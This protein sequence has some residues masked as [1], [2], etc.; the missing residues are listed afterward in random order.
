MP[1][2]KDHLNKKQILE[3]IKLRRSG[4]TIPMIASMYDRHHTTI[5]YWL[6]KVAP[7]LMP[8]KLKLKENVGRNQREG[9]AR[10]LGFKVLKSDNPDKYT[11]KVIVAKQ[12][13]NCS[14]SIGAKRDGVC[15]ICD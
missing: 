13:G 4:W 15:F 14:H 7:N 5:L 3:I 10:R 8:N 6:K 11:Y 2:R 9:W 1:G 12:G